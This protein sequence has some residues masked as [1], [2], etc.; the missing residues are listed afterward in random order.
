MSEAATAAI[1]R[2]IFDRSTKGRTLAPVTIPVE[3]GRI[4]FFSKVL[5]L[6][7]PIHSDPAAARRRGYPDVVAPPSFFIVLD[8][9][10][11]EARSRL[12]EGSVAELVN[13]DFRYLLHGDETYDYSGPVF[14]GDEVTHTTTITDFYDKKGGALEFATFASELNHRDR[15]VLVR[16]TRTLIHRLPRGHVG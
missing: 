13:C 5:G 10:A 6:A 11:E 15:G 14:A 16:A 12:R 1:P 2:G 9:E 7:D 3:R 4:Q 8:C